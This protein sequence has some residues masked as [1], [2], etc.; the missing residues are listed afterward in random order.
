MTR[1]TGE[2]IAQ[3]LGGGGVRVRSVAPSVVPP[4]PESV[5][6]VTKKRTPLRG[7]P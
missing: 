1:R 5:P 7:G 2:F 4:P 6:H 3:T